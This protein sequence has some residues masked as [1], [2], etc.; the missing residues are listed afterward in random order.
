MQTIRVNGV[1]ENSDFARILVAADFRMKRM[2]MGF[3]KSPVRN[4]PSYLELVNVASATSAMPR[5]WLAPNYDALLKDPEGLAWELR[6]KGV[7]CMT[8]DS[9]FSADGTRQQTGKSSDAAQKWADSM[10]ANYDELCV[11]EPVFG[12]LRNLMDLAVVSALII[13]ER[14]HERA[15][16]P[17]SLLTD[18]MAIAVHDFPAPKQVSSK[19]NALKK[20]RNWIISASGGVEIN[21]WEVASRTE[22]SPKLSSVRQAKPAAA[23]SWYWE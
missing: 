15:E 2:G 14:L 1:P 10:T 8:E 3:D 19:A 20:G 6:G 22:A 17:L 5:W 23:K 11:A 4:M 18:P 7:K 9:L 16:C 21:S 12:E 13:K